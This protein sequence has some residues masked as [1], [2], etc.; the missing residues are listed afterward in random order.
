MKET[1]PHDVAT[2]PL[3]HQDR[4]DGLDQSGGA[5]AFPRTAEPVKSHVRAGDTG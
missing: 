5:G 1:H 4:A 3:S 2:T